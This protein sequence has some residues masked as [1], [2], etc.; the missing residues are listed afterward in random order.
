MRGDHQVEDA[1]VADNL[2]TESDGEAV[3][4]KARKDILVDS[5]VWPSEDPAAVLADIENV[6]IVG[7]DHPQNAKGPRVSDFVTAARSAAS[8]GA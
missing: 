7:V 3:R 5:S 6:V 2:G 8:Q 4:I 1:L